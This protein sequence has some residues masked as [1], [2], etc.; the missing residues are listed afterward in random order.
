MKRGER[1]D[2]EK[3]NYTGE[4]RDRNEYDK[5]KGLTGRTQK[6]VR[7]TTDRGVVCSDRRSKKEFRER[8]LEN[9]LA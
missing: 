4:K 3:D 7:V 5:G 1:E 2:E 8:N 6:G 9:S